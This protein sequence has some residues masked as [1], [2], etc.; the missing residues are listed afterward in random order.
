MKH[1]S[2]TLIKIPKTEHA[3]EAPCVTPSEE[4]QGAISRKDDGFDLFG[5]VRGES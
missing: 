1:G 3:L 2:I 4:I 5:I